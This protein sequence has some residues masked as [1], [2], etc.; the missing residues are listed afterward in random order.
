MLNKLTEERCHTSRPAFS[1]AKETQT[2]RPIRVWLVDDDEPT[3][4]L[5]AS[6]V[7]GKNEIECSQG[8]SS[9]EDALRALEVEIPPDL[10][11][12][13]LQMRGQSGIEALPKIK[14]AAP[15]TQVLI[16]TTFYDCE[17]KSRALQ[18][19]A[20]GFL[21]K[22]YPIGRIVDCIGQACARPAPGPKIQ[23]VRRSASESNPWVSNLAVTSLSPTCG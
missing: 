20:S 9:A 15:A 4:S 5:L 12:L 1:N 10:I 13:D 14:S 23:G 22:R 16:L 2:R 19:G 18:A 3:R 8:F 21:L 11:L 17:A 7:Q 6:L